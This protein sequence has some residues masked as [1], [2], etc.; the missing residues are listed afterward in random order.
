MDTPQGD[1]EGEGRAGK[2][3]ISREQGRR[4]RV[5]DG[6]AGGHIRI[7]GADEARGL[8]GR[9]CRGNQIHRSP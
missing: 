1:V 6:S 7:P 9:G 3:R 2:A 5:E 8:Q 4:T